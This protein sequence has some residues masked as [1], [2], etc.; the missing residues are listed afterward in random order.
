MLRSRREVLG[1]FVLAATGLLLAGPS[2]NTAH[3]AAPASRAS[4]SPRAGA[5]ANVGIEVGALFASSVVTSVGPVAMGG[6]PVRLQDRRGSSFTVDLLRHD[7]ETPGVARA[8]SLDAFVSNDGDGVSATD[9]GH[10]LAAMA[11]AA[12]LAARESSGTRPPLLLTLRERAELRGR[13]SG[14]RARP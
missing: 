2:A 5:D 12:H 1:G 14:S 13:K 4:Q 11:I 10:G 6:L 9:E 3:A 7:P 8:G